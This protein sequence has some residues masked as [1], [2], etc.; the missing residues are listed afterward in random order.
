MA[1]AENPFRGCA[2]HSSL[3]VYLVVFNTVSIKKITLQEDCVTEK[4]EEWRDGQTDRRNKQFKL[5]YGL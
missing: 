3:F 2:V 5:N 4:T 1:S